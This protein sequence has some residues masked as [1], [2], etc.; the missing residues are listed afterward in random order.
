MVGIATLHLGAMEEGVGGG[1]SVLYL[2]ATEA[3]WDGDGGGQH[4]S[5]TFARGWQW[6]KP[7]GRAFKLL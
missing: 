2:H 3:G 1:T 6:W 7:G 4:C 5:L